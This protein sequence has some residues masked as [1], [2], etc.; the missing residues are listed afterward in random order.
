MC[1]AAGIEFTRPPP[2]TSDSSFEYFP[3]ILVRLGGRP[4]NWIALYPGHGMDELVLSVGSWA[5]S[6]I[7]FII[8]DGH[9]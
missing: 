9:L 2:S 7:T 4:Q 5:V 3:R 6:R 8:A 1:I